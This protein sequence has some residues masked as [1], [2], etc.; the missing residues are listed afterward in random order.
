ME[1][2]SSVSVSTRENNAESQQRSR[3]FT[4]PQPIAEEEQLQ[5]HD[6]P[7]TGEY[8]AQESPAAAFV[9]SVKK[10]FAPCVGVVD[11]ASVLIGECRP[12]LSKYDTC[13]PNQQPDN[14]ADDVI[15]RL[16]ERNG[17]FAQQSVRRRSETLEIPTHGMLFDDDDVSAISSH[18][19]EEMERLRQVQNRRLSNTNFHMSPN[20]H[21]SN[22]KSTTSNTTR[23]RRPSAKP[24]QQQATAISY[25]A[26]K[27]ISYHAAFTNKQLW[28]TQH[29][30]VP[31]RTT[32][33]T[34]NGDLSICVS[35]SD[36]SSSEGIEQG[37]EE[38]ACVYTAPPA[39]WGRTAG[40][41]QDYET[42]RVG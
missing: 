15:M 17:G 18:T 5:P 38:V 2:N 37:K 13:D 26:K 23:P 32:Y 41:N 27:A 20:M 9:D 7:A 31:T 16:R 10:F 25:H 4:I 8:D 40:K 1:Q 6:E 11:A 21:Y 22:Y 24:S 42:H 39:S 36:S 35:A 14:V 12:K 28:N 34:Y 30:P 33:A 3:N 29:S 19:L